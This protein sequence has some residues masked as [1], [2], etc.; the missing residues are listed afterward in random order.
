MDY[1]VKNGKYYKVI[2]RKTNNLITFGELTKGQVLSTIHKVIFIS[3]Q[4]YLAIKESAD[5]T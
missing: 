5:L 4:E 3:E 2:D 1:N